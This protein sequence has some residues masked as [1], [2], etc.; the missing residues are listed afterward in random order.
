MH[1]EVANVLGYGVRQSAGTVS[2]AFIHLHKAKSSYINVKH[3]RLNQR[4]RSSVE[5]L[6]VPITNSRSIL[7]FTPSR[8]VVSLNTSK[9][10]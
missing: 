10:A 8:N 1:N 4:A 7:P 3:L 9:C 5:F 6:E 2:T